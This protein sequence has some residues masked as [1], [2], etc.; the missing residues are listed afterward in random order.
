MI[1]LWQALAEA[2]GTLIFFTIILTYGNQPIAVAVGLLAAI[3]AFG[4]MSGGHF[5][6]AVSFMMFIKGDI[7]LVTLLTY[8]AAQMVGAIVAVLWWRYTVKTYGKTLP[9]P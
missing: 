4:R 9:C 2:I 6:S 3:Y 8:V 1:I 7:D 5:N